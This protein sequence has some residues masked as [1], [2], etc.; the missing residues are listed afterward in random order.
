M[1]NTTQ[2]RSETQVNQLAAGEAPRLKGVLEGTYNLT[3]GGWTQNLIYG[4]VQQSARFVPR[5][6]NDVRQRLPDA[7]AAELHFRCEFFVPQDSQE[8]NDF[9]KIGEPI[10]AW[11]A[12]ASF[13]A[14]PFVTG[15]DLAPFRLV[16]ILTPVPEEADDGKAIPQ[17]ESPLTSDL[18]LLRSLKA[19]AAAAQ[20]PIID[21]FSAWFATVEGKSFESYEETFEAVNLIRYFTKL[22]GCSLFFQGKPVTIQCVRAPRAKRGVI[23]LRTVTKGKQRAVFAGSSMPIVEIKPAYE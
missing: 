18:Q 16:I 1:T 19:D 14:P 9:R 6:L 10:Q 7:P 22:S 15:G 2:T 8:L 3:S 4:D 13:T 21:R 23:Q 12:N 11:L 17:P 20:A 5:V